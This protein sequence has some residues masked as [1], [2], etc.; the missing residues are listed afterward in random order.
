MTVNMSE[1]TLEDRL[2]NEVADIRKE[3]LAIKTKQ[4]IG[5]DN[6]VIGVTNVSNSVTTVPAGINQYFNF[7][8]TPVGNRLTIWNL[9]FSVYVD[10]VGFAD[11][12]R[13]PD[14]SN[15]VGGML[16]MKVRYW[17]DW[18]ISS[19]STGLRWYWICVENYDT[20]SH[21]IGV[22]AAAYAIKSAATGATT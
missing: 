13:F 5:G 9:F 22:R 4:F 12:N 8:L 10:G 20:A 6:T 19:D 17:G 2:V 1:Q 16:K 21:V 7:T 3:L 11:N 15:L 14:G 18:A